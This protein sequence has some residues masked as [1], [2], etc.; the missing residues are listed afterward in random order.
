V[1]HRS[2]KVIQPVCFAINGRRAHPVL[3]RRLLANQPCAGVFM[4]A[5]SS[6]E[7]PIAKAKAQLQLQFKVI[8]FN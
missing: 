1:A 3:R 6:I 2:W 4:S 5:S 8:V 7:R